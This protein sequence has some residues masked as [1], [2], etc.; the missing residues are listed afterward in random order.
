MSAALPRMSSQ[1]TPETIDS[2]K[3]DAW[4]RLGRFVAAFGKKERWGKAKSLQKKLIRDIFLVFLRV[5]FIFGP[6]ISIKLGFL[7]GFAF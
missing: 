3:K 2:L 1:A 5:Y 4:P 6:R 7:H